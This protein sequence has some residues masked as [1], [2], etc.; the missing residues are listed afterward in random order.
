MSHL[1]RRGN[2]RVH[3]ALQSHLRILQTGDEQTKGNRSAK[4]RT[5]KWREIIND[6]EVFPAGRQ[7]R[8]NMTTGKKEV[9]LESDELDSE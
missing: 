1:V 7:F 8:M 3:S 4:V 5:G 6:D 9:E 2:G